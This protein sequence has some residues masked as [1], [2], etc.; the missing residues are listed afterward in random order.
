MCRGDGERI[1]RLTDE[2][3]WRRME[4]ALCDSG[5]NMEVRGMGRS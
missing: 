2:N 4:R 5:R 3:R 1:E